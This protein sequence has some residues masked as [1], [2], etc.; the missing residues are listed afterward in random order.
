MSSD[1]RK[2]YTPPS[3]STEIVWYNSGPEVDVTILQTNGPDLQFTEENKPCFDEW[4]N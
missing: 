4:I 2:K 3:L 1:A